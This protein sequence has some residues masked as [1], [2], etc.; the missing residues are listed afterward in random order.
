MINDITIE[1]LDMLEVVE[2]RTIPDK[3]A[4]VAQF[5]NE[6]NKAGALAHAESIL[7]AN[8]PTSYIWD[9]VSNVVMPRIT[10]KPSMFIAHI[11]Q[12]QGYTG[13]EVLMFEKDGVVVGYQCHEIETS[14]S[15]APGRGVQIGAEMR[16]STRV[17]LA[18]EELIRS[19]L[20]DI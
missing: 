5:N 12:N 20:G 10:M 8:W 19:A 3:A 15:I 17:G 1:D 14:D 13:G 4:V 9:G 16:E 18:A 11:T 6:V 2:E 7:A